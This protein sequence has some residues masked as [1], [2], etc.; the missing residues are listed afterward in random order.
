MTRRRPWPNTFQDAFILNAEVLELKSKPSKPI[1]ELAEDAFGK[2]PVFTDR[3][4]MLRA[5]VNVGREDID[6]HGVVPLDPRF[7]VLGASSGYLALDVSNA[8]ED[9]RVGDEIMFSV[10]YGALLAAMTS[11][12]VKKNLFRNGTLYDEGEQ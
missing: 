2:R 9:I 1:G 10:N 8:E 3:G 4:E 7:T 12:Y 11:Q 6:V 5:L